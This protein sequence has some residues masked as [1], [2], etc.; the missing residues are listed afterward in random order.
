MIAARRRLELGLNYL[1][2]TVWPDFDYT[3]VIHFAGPG[4]AEDML[5]GW[6]GI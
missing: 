4:H 2:D 3:L 5:S 6:D 1:F